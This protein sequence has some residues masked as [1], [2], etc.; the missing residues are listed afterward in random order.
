MAKGR[1][2]RQVGYGKV[3]IDRQVTQAMQTDAGMSLKERRR[4]SDDP[5]GVSASRRRRGRQQHAL[6]G[7]SRCQAGCH[8]LAVEVVG[9]GSTRGCEV[10]F[11][12]GV[13]TSGRW[14]VGGGQSQSRAL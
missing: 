2:V 8:N 14:Q 4:R 9:L 12:G 11:Q 3:Y 5:A 1:E 6:M 7:E 10:A 13:F